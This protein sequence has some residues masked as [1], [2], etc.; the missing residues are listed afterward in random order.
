MG[1]PAPGKKVRPVPKPKPVVSDQDC[2]RVLD[3]YNAHRGKLPAAESLDGKRRS[4]IAAAVKEH[5]LEVCLGLVAD[6]TKEVSTNKWWLQN[7]Y[8]LGNLLRHLVPKAEAWRSQIQTTP[9]R[10]DPRDEYRI[11][12]QEVAQA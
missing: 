6:A 9:T 10:P 2:Q 3:A 8:S 11:K 5:G 4:A 12:R 7:R 1:A